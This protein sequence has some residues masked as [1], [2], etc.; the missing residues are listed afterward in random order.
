MEGGH[1]I[2]SYRLSYRI[3]MVIP[4]LSTTMMCIFSA[5]QRSTPTLPSCL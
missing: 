3:V 5:H 2:W 4:C 1:Q